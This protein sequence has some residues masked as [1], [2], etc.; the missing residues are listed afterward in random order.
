MTHWR[1]GGRVEDR[2]QLSEIKFFHDYSK[3]FVNILKLEV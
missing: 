3:C 2:L 1:G